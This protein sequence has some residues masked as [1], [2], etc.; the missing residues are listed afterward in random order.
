[1]VLAQH[2]VE[3]LRIAEPVSEYHR[4]I[5]WFA[6]QPRPLLPRNVWDQTALVT[7]DL[8]GHPQGRQVHRQSYYDSHPS[9]GCCSG[10]TKSL[11]EPHRGTHLATTS[12]RHCCHCDQHHNLAGGFCFPNS[13]WD[14]ALQS[15]C[16]RRMAGPQGQVLQAGH[17]TQLHR[18]HQR[19]C[20]LSED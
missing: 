9:G 14:A 12:S 4:P 6:A 11:D 3:Q 18:R 10:S 13:P 20:Y 5:N 19:R 15:L 2:I 8:Q 7:P 16:V 1:L 17:L